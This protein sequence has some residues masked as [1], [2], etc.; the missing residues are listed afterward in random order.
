MQNF[1]EKVNFLFLTK[2]YFFSSYFLQFS[3]EILPIFP[4]SS[5][6]F[7]R[8]QFTVMKIDSVLDTHTNEDTQSALMK[9]KF[10]R[11]HLYLTTI[12]SQNVGYMH[13]SVHV[14]CQFTLYKSQSCLNQIFSK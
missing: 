4:V 1:N 2:K 13:G 11:I 7:F 10:V 12:V 14:M 5:L 3:L 6:S 9:R 8:L